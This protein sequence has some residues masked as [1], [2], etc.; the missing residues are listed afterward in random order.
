MNSQQM[1][2]WNRA[3][4]CLMPVAMSSEALV[5]PSHQRLHCITTGESAPGC[6][7]S[8]CIAWCHWQAK[9]CVWSLQRWW[10]MR[11]TWRWTSEA[12]SL[13]TCPAAWTHTASG[14]R[15]GCAAGWAQLCPVLLLQLRSPANASLCEAT[16]YPAACRQFMG[17]QELASL[18]AE[19]SVLCRCV[20][21]SVPSTS[22]P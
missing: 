14:S 3:K 18:R 13:R 15:L 1:S 22:R 2:P 21:A 12:S 9:M 19:M 4:L 8:S 16:A 5:R 7:S 20:R 6:C 10:S 11:A 17:A